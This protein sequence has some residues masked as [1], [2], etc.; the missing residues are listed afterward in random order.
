MFFLENLSTEE[1]KRVLHKFEATGGVSQRYYILTTMAVIIATFGMILDSPSIVIGAMLVA[2]LMSPI[3]LT[4]ISIITGRVRML[5][6]SLDASI[7]GILLSIM[8]ATFISLFV[9]I[10]ELPNEVLLRAHPGILDMFVA[11]AAGAVGMFVMIKK[12]T[13]TLPGVAISVSLMPPLSAIG[14]GLATR[15]YAI[16]SG[17]TLLFI[18]NLIAIIAS[19]A[20]V[21]FLFGFRPYAKTKEGIVKQGAYVSIILLI[22]LGFIL[23]SS[24]INISRSEKLRSDVK[25]ELTRQIKALGI[26]SLDSFTVENKEDQLNIKTVILSNRN[27]TPEDMK[28]L[29]NALAFRTEKSVKINATIIPTLQGGKIIA[30]EEKAAIQQEKIKNPDLEDK[31]PLASDSAKPATPSA[32]KKDPDVKGVYSSGKPLPV[33][34]DEK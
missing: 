29:T 3:L 34:W 8:I 24:F 23:T 19:G 30:P 17:A 20:L 32:Q 12:D 5:N 18:T 27:P 6:R 2:P 25:D 15:N 13:V 4:S 9:P 33:I 22:V 10:Y 16:A 7:K 14:I 1:K 26:G 28:T 21:L 31:A 11:L